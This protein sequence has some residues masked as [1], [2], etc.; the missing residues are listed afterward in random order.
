MTNQRKVKAN[1]PRNQVTAHCLLFFSVLLRREL[2]HWEDVL[3]NDKNAA[4]ETKK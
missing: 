1:L 3:Y 4:G 2:V